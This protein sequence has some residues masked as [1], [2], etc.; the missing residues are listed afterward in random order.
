MSS[1]EQFLR[2]RKMHDL[3]RIHLG[4]A[5]IQLESDGGWR[6]ASGAPSFHRFLVNEGLDPR[7]MRP[8]MAVA[9]K[10][11]LDLGLSAEVIAGY[12]ISTLGSLV[13]VVNLENIK[14]ILGAL[15]SMPAPEARSF[16]HAAYGPGAG[17]GVAGVSVTK[18]AQAALSLLDSMQQEDRADFIKAVSRAGAQHV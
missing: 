2:S 1:Y 11:I 4:L 9:S 14:D 15:E 16:I 5:L 8:Y 13:N 10:Y 3:A 18:K 6:G 7:V 17:P 12:G